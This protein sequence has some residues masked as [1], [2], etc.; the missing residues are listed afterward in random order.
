MSYNAV[1]K[2][3]HNYVTLSDS[4]IK[5]L[6]SL[7]RIKEV[8][9]RQFIVEQG[10]ICRHES[11]VTRGCLRCYYA[12]EDGNEHIVH[13]AI[14]DWWVADLNSFLTQS[15]AR[16][17]IDAIEPSEVIQI[18]HQNRQQLLE[19]AP[20]FERYFRLIVQNAFVASQQR[21]IDSYSKDATKRYHEFKKRYPNIENRVPQYMIASYLGI[22]PEFLSNIRANLAN[23]K[24]R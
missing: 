2:H 19:R 7:T 12:D 13:F 21:I 1:V 3:I 5:A 14:E 22:T 18:D 11:F 15:P 4:D 23:Q 16:F 24:R 8:R 20:K 9:K 10:E 6:K 17:S